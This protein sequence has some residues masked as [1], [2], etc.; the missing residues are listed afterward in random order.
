MLDDVGGLEGEDLED[1]REDLFVGYGAGAE[2]VDMHADGKR[3][4]NGVGKLHL[5]LAGKPGGHDVFRNPAAHVGGR[6][7]DL[8]RVLAGKRATAVTAHA[9]VG[10]D[11]DL[12]A[13]ETGVPLRTTDDEVAGGVDEILGLLGEHVFRQHLFDDLL[14]AE[15]FDLGVLH[16]GRVL[17]G[18]HD[19]DDAGRTT[20]DILDRHLRLGI[21]TQPLDLAG[22]ADARELATE[23]VSVH[24][25]RRHE[26]WRFIASVTKHDALVACTLLG[27]LFAVRLLGIHT[28][29]DVLRLVGKVVVDEQR[30][31]VEDIVVVGVTDAS[32]RIADDLLKVDDRANG[33]FADLRNG[34]LATDHNH[35]ALHKGFAGHAALGVHAQAGVKNGI[36][37]RVTN[38]VWMTFANGFGGKNVGAHGIVNFSYRQI[39]MR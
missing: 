1:G 3:V 27:S 7:V 4:T 28:L 36:G 18:N 17:S 31:G 30:V 19:I 38:L 8:R 32:H 9:A 14:D 25:R 5:A 20:I 12:A 2:G 22:L 34:D 16:I 6:A 13:G 24:D 37:N 26:L 33:L 10:V 23:A 39:V 11:D 29:R 21:R 35:V 15:F